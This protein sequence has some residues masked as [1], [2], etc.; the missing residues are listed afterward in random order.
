[1]T[2]TGDETSNDELCCT[3]WTGANAADLDDNTND[4]GDTADEDSPATAKFVAEL[5]NEDGTAETTDSIDGDNE[6]L[7]ATVVTS[8]GEHGEERITLNDTRHDTL[9]VTEEKEIGGGDGGDE[10]LKGSTR[11]SPV[12]GNTLAVCRDSTSHLS[13]IV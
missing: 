5:E 9:V 7:P 8:L 13:G 2:Y 3:S 1:M 12:C 11:A 6:A 10:H 4:H